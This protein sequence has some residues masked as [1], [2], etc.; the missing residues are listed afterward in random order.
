MARK[1]LRW[2]EQ[3]HSNKFEKYKSKVM[4]SIGRPPAPSPAGI[5][6]LFIHAIHPKMQYIWNRGHSS[7][8]DIK[9]I[10]WKILSTFLDNYSYI[11]YFIFEKFLHLFLISIRVTKFC[12]NCEKKEAVFRIPAHSCFVEKYKMRALQWENDFNTV[13]A[14]NSQFIMIF[15]ILQQCLG[16]LVV[17]SGHPVYISDGYWWF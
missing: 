15:W 11:S 17:L 16:M 14:Y 2:S 3:I 7:N 5:S 13:S 12:E 1:I 4:T 6:R 10:Q 8:I 9:F